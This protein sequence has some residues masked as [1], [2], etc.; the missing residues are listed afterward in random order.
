MRNKQPWLSTTERDSE[1]IRMSLSMSVLKKALQSLQTQ[2][3]AMLEHL[4]TLPTFTHGYNHEC[5]TRIGSRLKAMISELERGQL[6]RQRGRKGKHQHGNS[7]KDASL[8]GPT[9]NTRISLSS[10]YIPCFFIKLSIN[11]DFKR[12]LSETWDELIDPADIEPQRNFEEGI[13]S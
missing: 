9:A 4:Y 1:A 11:R 2:L 13:Y 5:Q 10:W 6:Y 8:Y 12:A 3:G 7:L